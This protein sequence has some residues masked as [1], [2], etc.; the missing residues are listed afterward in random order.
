[1]PSTRSC[2]DLSIID[3][4][5]KIEFP[6]R[7]TRRSSNRGKAVTRSENKTETNKKNK[8]SKLVEVET[9]PSK[10]TRKRN[11]LKSKLF[12]IN[13]VCVLWPPLKISLVSI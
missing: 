1:M 8:H 9:F 13:S 7:K 11:N 3:N 2:K 4:Q 6:C 12:I 5:K 10:T